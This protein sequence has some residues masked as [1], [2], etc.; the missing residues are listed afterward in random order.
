MAASRTTSYIYLLI[1]V[2]TGRFMNSSNAHVVISSSLS[3]QRQQYTQTTKRTNNERYVHTDGQR[4]RERE[5]EK[6]ETG[7]LPDIQDQRYADCRSGI[8]L[9]TSNDLIV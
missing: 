2:R 4:E 5:R 3:K 8:L 6:R 9:V 1:Y 7:A